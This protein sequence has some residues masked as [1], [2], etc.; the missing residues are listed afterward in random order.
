[1][2]WTRTFP[3]TTKNTHLQTQLRESQQQLHAKLGRYTD[4]Q[5]INTNVANPPKTCETKL[6]ENCNS[7]KKSICPLKLNFLKSCLVYKAAFSSENKRDGSCSRSFKKRFHNHSSSFGHQRVD[8]RTEASL[9]AQKQRSR[10]PNTAM[11]Q[12]YTV[13][14]RQKSYKS[15]K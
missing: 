10:L 4:T 7:R 13:F 9:G 2:Y 5:V 6:T 1:M 3:L 11:M 14:V 15:S 8:K 12:K